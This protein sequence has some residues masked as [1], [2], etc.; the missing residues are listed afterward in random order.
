M[1]APATAP[2]ATAA[3][4]GPA[5]LSPLSPARR[6]QRWLERNALRI[7]GFVAFT[8]LFTPIAGAGTQ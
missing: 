6:A 1:T 3:P 7:F 8:Y 4:A 2:T 5:V